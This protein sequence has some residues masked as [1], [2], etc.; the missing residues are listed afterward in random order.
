MKQ[1][2][3]KT[4][5]LRVSLGPYLTVTGRTWNVNRN[6]NPTITLTPT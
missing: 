4:T 3:S 1:S 5:L 2:P 6:F